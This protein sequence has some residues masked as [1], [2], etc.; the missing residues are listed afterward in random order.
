MGTRIK[1]V[2]AVAALAVGLGVTSTGTADA[3]GTWHY[4]KNETNPSMAVKTPGA[5][6]QA[7]EGGSF[8]QTA[9]HT[10]LWCAPLRTSPVSYHFTYLKVNLATGDV[11][12]SDGYLRGTIAAPLPTNQQKRNVKRCS[13][14]I[15]YR[16]GL[17]L[18]L[19][20]GS[21]SV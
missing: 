1:R 5:S 7:A 8:A 19:K 18:L 11:C 15:T 13:G 9:W 4:F 20:S 21:G 16:V 14:V 12:S 17:G 2:A 6:C 10:V 3:A